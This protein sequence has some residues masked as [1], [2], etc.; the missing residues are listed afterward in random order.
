M[1]ERRRFHRWHLHSGWSQTNCF[2]W[3][4]YHYPEVLTLFLCSSGR[5]IWTWFELSYWWWSSRVAVIRYVKW[6]PCSRKETERKKSVG[7]LTSTEEEVYP[8]VAI[9]PQSGRWYW[10]HLGVLMTIDVYRY[11]QQQHQQRDSHQSHCE[12]HLLNTNEVSG[13]RLT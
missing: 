12:L 13:T 2:I 5:S 3:A 4:N 8:M 11:N 10:P 7:A 9:V 1:T 6:L